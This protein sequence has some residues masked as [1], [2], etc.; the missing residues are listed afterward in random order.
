[1]KHLVGAF[2]TGDAIA[3]NLFGVAMAGPLDNGQVDAQ[4]RYVL[5]SAYDRG[6]GSPRDSVKAAIWRC[7][8]AV[9]GAP[10]ARASLGAL[11]A[12][13]ESVPQDYAQA[14][15]WGA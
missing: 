10:D 2:C 15:K 8:A 6:N 4:A 12:L 9:Q 3:L 14:A 13:G 5:G 7:N 1:V 11:Y